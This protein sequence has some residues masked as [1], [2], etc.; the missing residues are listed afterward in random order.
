MLCI[1]RWPLKVRAAVPEGLVMVLQNPL[2]HAQLSSVLDHGTVPLPHL[3]RSL[4]PER[5]STPSFFGQIFR[6]VTTQF[7]IISATSFKFQ[8]NIIILTSLLSKSLIFC[9]IWRLATSLSTSTHWS[10]FVSF[11]F[12]STMLRGNIRNLRSHCN[13]KWIIS[14]TID[15]YVYSLKILLSHVDICWNIWS[16]YK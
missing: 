11:L 10:G 6:K 16:I 3:F 5:F 15:K 7:L 14:I 4:P 1:Q 12:R 8:W 13:M 9:E 2:T